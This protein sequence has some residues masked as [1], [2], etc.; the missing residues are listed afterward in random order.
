MKD[1]KRMINNNYTVLD[2]VSMRNKINLQPQIK[3]DSC[4]EEYWVI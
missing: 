3:Y 4:T 2:H 1:I